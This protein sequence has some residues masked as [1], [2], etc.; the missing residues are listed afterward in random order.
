MSVRVRE[1][2]KGIKKVSKWFGYS[3]NFLKHNC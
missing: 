2:E 3:G 1:R